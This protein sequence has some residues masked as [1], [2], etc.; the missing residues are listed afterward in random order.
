M[1]RLRSLGVAARGN[2]PVET[3]V[4]R[5]VV[6][7][8][9]D[10]RPACRGRQHL[11]SA[12]RHGGDE[13]I[14][15]A[16]ELGAKFAIDTEV[17]HEGN[18]SVRITSADSTRAYVRSIEPIPVAPGEKISG[19]FWVK[20]KDVPLEPGAIIAIA[21]FS[22]SDDK[23]NEE[24]VAKFDTAKIAAANALS[25]M[26][27]RRLETAA[28]VPPRAS[29]PVADTLRINHASATLAPGDEVN[30]HRHAFEPE[31][32]SQPV[33]DVV[34]VVAGHPLAGVDLDREPGRPLAGL[35]HEQ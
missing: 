11:C 7:D 25:T 19:S 30:H 14:T 8:A 5:R 32:V 17:K 33:L 35:S 34:R 3:E 28:R 27:P 23:G 16:R 4:H 22:N 15:R 20:C 9:V 29:E 10:L 31:V 12:L 2:A 1:G 21:D 26:R 18:Q 6:E 13:D 24:T